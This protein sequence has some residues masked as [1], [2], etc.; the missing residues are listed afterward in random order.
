MANAKKKTS[1]PQELVQK[2]K[3][4]QAIK[5]LVVLAK[6]ADGNQIKVIPKA[7]TNG[8]L[9]QLRE[10]G[11]D[12][13]FWD[14]KPVVARLQNVDA[15]DPDAIAQAYLETAEKADAIMRLNVQFVDAVL[16]LVYPGIDFDD[17]PQPDCAKLTALTYQLT[18]GREIEIKN[19]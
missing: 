8:Q 10:K 6:D 7:M 3:K 1:L 5:P 18:Q 17:T 4:E 19:S 16:E 9:R 15:N 11:L 12:P 13:M 2:A 14:D